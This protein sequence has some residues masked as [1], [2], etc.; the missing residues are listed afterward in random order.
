ML[1]YKKTN[2][3]LIIF[4]LKHKTQSYN[5]ELNINYQLLKILFLIIKINISFLK[6]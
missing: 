1:K 6:F 3:L 5:K 4:F 2:K